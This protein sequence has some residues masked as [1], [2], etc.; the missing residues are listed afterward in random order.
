MLRGK[1]CGLGYLPGVVKL[2]ESDTEN[3]IPIPHMG[4]NTL[5]L[6][7]PIQQEFPFANSFAEFYFLHSYFFESMGGT[8]ALG[9]T[10][11]GKDF[12]ALAA[13]KNV[14]GMQCHPEKSHDCGLW[15]LKHFGEMKNE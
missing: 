6:E 12:V 9:F 4:W 10:K 7:N 5:H 2:L 3:P 8:K 13:Y 15:F 14:I 11:Y 1:L